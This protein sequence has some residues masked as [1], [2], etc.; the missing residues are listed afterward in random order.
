LATKSIV[1]PII[2][3]KRSLKKLLKK[4]CGPAFMDACY[5]LSYLFAIENII[6]FS[7]KACCMQCCKII[8]LLPCLL[9]FNFLTAQNYQAIHGSSYAGS[10]GAAGNPASIVHVPFAWDITPF[11]VQL[12]QSTNA[13]KIKNYSLLSSPNNIKVDASNGVKKRFVF[14]NQDIHLLNARF[15]LN[16]KSAIAFGANFRSYSYATTNQSNYQ[17]TSYSLAD[18][19]KI[20]TDYIPLTAQAAG[21][22]WAEVYG[23]YARTITDDGYHLLN[24]GITL[25]VNKSLAGGYARA[26]DVQYIQNPGADGVMGYLL[27]Q[28]N[29]Q[30]GYS[31]NIDLI[32]SNQTSAVNRKA[33]LNNTYTGFSAD[34]GIEYI[35]L[36]QDEEEGDDYSYRTKIG[37]S[38]MD[39]GSTKYKHSSK[40]RYAVAGKEGITDTLLEN[41][42]N[43][44]RS[45]DDF[46]DSLATVAEFTTGLPGDFVIYQPTRL[47]INVDQHLVD[48]FFVNAELT[49]PLIALAKNSLYIRDMNLLAITPRWETKHFGAYLPL[50]MNTRQ[51]VW[52]GGAFRAGPVLLGTHNL[53]N[54]FSKNSFQNG[55]LY[56]AITIRPGKKR[57]RNQEES[58]GKLNK[59]QEKNL[60]CPK[61]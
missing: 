11:S 46:N 36:P 24:A 28:G 47:I 16:A 60:N 56:L 53:A 18:Y 6:L 33:F 44:V 15:A 3:S 58:N 37:V 39:I 2:K 52:V 49:L 27:T 10:L 9:L 5:L 55:G 35:L 21:S 32:D 23:S 51:Q 61:F 41:K 30:Y 7:Q 59:Q 12:K 22:A 40:S 13:Y 54:L 45:V 19:L 38:I 4:K 20:N 48:N 1:N 25:K 57:D 43:P 50:L 17:D 42:F 8:L 26:Q 14:T 34:V 31:S 29:L